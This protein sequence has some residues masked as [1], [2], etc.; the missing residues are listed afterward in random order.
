MK[1]YAAMLLLICGTGKAVAQCPYGGSLSGVEL[2]TN[3]DFSSGNTGFTSDYTYCNTFQCLF[4]EAYYAVGANPNYFHSAFYGSDHTTGTGKLMIVNGAGLT[5]VNIWCETVT[6]QPYANYIFSYWLSSM[7]TSSP[8][9]LQVSINGSLVG[10]I[11]VAPSSLYTWEQSAVTWNAGSNTSVEICIVNQNTTLG[12]NDFG[13]D[14]ISFQQCVCTSILADAGPDVEICPGDSAQLSASGGAYYT[15]QTS[16]FLSDSSVSDPLA[17]PAS[18]TQFYVTV[19]D[20]AGCSGID[21]T[22]VFIYPPPQVIVS[23]DTS[24]CT[25]TSAS[26]LASGGISYTWSP[27][28]TLSNPIIADPL[29]LPDT[30]TTYVVTVTDSNGC[31]ASDSV[32]VG[33]LALPQ[34]TVSADTVIC[35]FTAATLTASGGV[36]YLWSNGTAGDTSIVFPLTDSTFSVVVTDS[37]G[38]SGTASV[39]VSIAL[40]SLT[41]EGDTQICIGDFT[42]LTGNGALTYLWIS[43][44]DTSASITVS[45]SSDTTVVLIGFTGTCFDTASVPV[46][47]SP[48]PNADAGPNAFIDLGS[49]ITLNVSGGS[50]ALWSPGNSLSCTACLSTEA[51]PADTTTYFVT[52]TDANGCSATDSV[53]VFVIPPD[54]VFIPNAFTPNGDGLNDEL[55]PVLSGNTATKSLSVFNRWG[56]QVF[57][58]TSPGTGW[59]GSYQG[60]PEDIGVF[61]YFFSGVNVVTG[62]EIVKQGN[63]LLLR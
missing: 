36:T 28:S 49:G 62:K 42:V 56:Q 29:A 47:V 14:D 20:S 40:E 25:G 5:N 31:D 32:Q 21:S 54:E 59:D 52:V 61:V 63:V 48:L 19:F 27:S 10:N 34:P 2:I 22:T 50:S 45:P 23:D 16:P 41:I 35:K 24:V 57:F 51:T 13:L 18:T 12:G 43:T 60:K 4:P 33:L 7:V 58:T 44:G 37:N 9:E 46:Q 6:V 3:S 39:N 38:C 8:A 1:K 17:F 11:S 30:I 55:L 53:T 26:L 15:W